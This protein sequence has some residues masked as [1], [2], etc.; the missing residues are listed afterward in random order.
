M[1]GALSHLGLWIYTLTNEKS[2]SLLNDPKHDRKMRFALSDNGSAATEADSNGVLPTVSWRS[3]RLKEVAHALAEVSLQI[4]AGSAR[5]VPGQWP[6][7]FRRRTVGALAVLGVIRLLEVWVTGPRNTESWAFA[8][9]S[10]GSSASKLY[11]LSPQEP[12]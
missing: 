6:P 11:L 3:R 5:W 12:R 9:F 10:S 4:P 1:K 7:A 2:S 8:I